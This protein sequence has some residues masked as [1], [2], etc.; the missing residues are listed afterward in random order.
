[1]ERPTSPVWSRAALVVVALAGS[2]IVGLA[3]PVPPPPAPESPELIDQFEGNWDAV[4]TNSA[5]GA[6]AYRS[7]VALMKTWVKLRNGEP[8]VDVEHIR[9]VAA[10]SHF[11]YRRID[12]SPWTA[13]G[14]GT[15][16][17]LSAGGEM[18]FRHP[19]GFLGL[20]GGTSTLRV[21]GPGEL[22]GTWKYG[23]TGGTTVWRRV[24]PQIKEIEY[25][26]GITERVPP[27]RPGRL[28]TRYSG[29]D[30][31]FRGN[32][33]T[34]EISILGDNLWGG[35]R[36]YMEGADLEPHTVNPIYGSAGG[37]GPNNIA[38]LRLTI[39][40]WPKA[41]PGRK[42]LRVDDLR[43]PVDLEVTGYPED[44][45]ELSWLAGDNYFST[46]PA[47]TAQVGQTIVLRAAMPVGS[48]TEF[49][50]LAV[51]ITRADG[52]TEIRT[53]PVSRQRPGI[54]LESL[55][56]QL[57]SGPAADD[58]IGALAGDRLEAN[59]KGS[60]PAPLAVAAPD[61][62]IRLLQARPDG[63]FVEAA[64]PLVYG[65]AFFVEARFPTPRTA[66][67]PVVDLSWLPGQSEPIALHAVPNDPLLYRSREIRLLPPPRKSP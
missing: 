49:L 51:R 45:P 50:N 53:V 1:M 57:T 16:P 24:Q 26:S 6:E 31:Y 27:D 60:A 44:P 8:A 7:Q 62:A 61:A 66:G 5:T 30:N 21:A 59:F 10:P 19:Y 42:W 29:P 13:S 25:A 32:R 38:G 64:Y 37:I 15:N 47:T 34:A 9:M 41:S 20:W 58:S 14:H 54:Y 12:N 39:I 48:R 11:G 28:L 17:E 43:I 22:R 4:F 52:R 2:A 67:E 55:P 33:L 63:R 56:L 3:Q 46:T 35:H 18:T 40:F 36:V 23:D 65:T